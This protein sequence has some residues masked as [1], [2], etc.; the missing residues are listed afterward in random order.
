MEIEE[1]KSKVASAE[2][3]F[4]RED[5]H[6]GSRI[7]LLGLGGSYSY[8]T[9]NADSDLDIR[10]CALNSKAE[11]LTNENFEQFVN[12]ETDTVI[13]SFNKL[14]SLLSNVNPNTIELLGLKPEHYLYVSPIGKELLD[15]KKL[16]LSKRAAHSFG[17]TYSENL[18]A[19]DDRF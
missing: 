2:Y 6:L 18:R 4:L 1:I 15:N 5:A 12:E 11:I 10:G 16:F 7:I 14:I 9:N 17:G 19:Y 13:Y 3:D 8:G